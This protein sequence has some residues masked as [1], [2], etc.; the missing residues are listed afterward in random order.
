[1]LSDTKL[2]PSSWYSSTCLLYMTIYT[3][4]RE[5]RGMVEDGRLFEYFGLV[6]T[7][8]SD[9]APRT[10]PVSSWCWGAG[11]LGCLGSSF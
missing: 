9:K 6:L 11:V 2:G 10:L 4:Q 1:M 3:W 8:L 5:V 7:T